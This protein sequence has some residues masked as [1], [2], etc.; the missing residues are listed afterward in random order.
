MSE[1][2]IKFDQP[3]LWTPEATATVELAAHI[4]GMRMS[5]YTGLPA[6]DSFNAVIGPIQTWF[7]STLDTWASCLYGIIRYR[8]IRKVGIAI[9]VHEL[10]HALNVRAGLLPE[11]QIINDRI[12]L[13]AGSLWGGMHEHWQVEGEQPDEIFANLFA[14]WAL[15]MLNHNKAGDKLRAWM[16]EHMPA[17]IAEAMHERI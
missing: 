15:G 1:F 4:V 12:T 13:K 10:G 2:S 7:T 6:L 8:D 16:D 9:T 5:K 11:K 3:E 17:W 14:D